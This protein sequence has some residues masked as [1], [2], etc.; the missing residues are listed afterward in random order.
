[1]FTAKRGE[2]SAALQDAFGRLYAAVD[3]MVR[4]AQ[5]AGKLQR[6]D[7]DRLRLLLFATMQGIAALVTS[8]AV[9]SGQVDGLI[10]DAVALFTKSSA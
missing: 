10:A 5:Q 2:Q 8:G 1:M 7:P 6:G 3:G 9:S 4:R